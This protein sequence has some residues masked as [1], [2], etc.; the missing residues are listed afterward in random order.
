MTTYAPVVLFRHG[1]A[2]QTTSA[3]DETALRAKGWRNHERFGDD[4]PAQAVAAPPTP[5]TADE[6]A[7]A[8]AL[9]QD[10]ATAATDSELASAVSTINTALSGKQAA[11][12][13]ATDTELNAAISDL[14]GTYAPLP[15]GT[16]EVGQVPVVTDDSPLTLG[17]GEGGGGG[18]ASLVT[19]GASYL[20]VYSS[21]NQSIATDTDDV[22]VLD[23]TTVTSAG[24]DLTFDDAQNAI[25]I[26][27]DG[28][29]TI[30]AEVDWATDV[31]GNRAIHLVYT[32]AGPGMSYVSAAGYNKVPVAGLN[33]AVGN[34]IYLPRQTL[35]L[36]A[37]AIIQLSGWHDSTTDPLDVTFAELTVRKL[38]GVPT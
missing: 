13:A 7:A 2:R 35:V 30:V 3:L 22:I 27:A 24:T 11:A 34:G 12:T 19:P 37:G 8:V 25:V 29:Y 1:Q 6:V 17:W 33:A 21:V 9:L 15:T 32:D 20:D 18:G 10:K 36:P 5:A 28:L 14:A 31:V 4:V 16:P 26:G 23:E 38:L